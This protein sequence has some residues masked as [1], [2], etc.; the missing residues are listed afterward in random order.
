MEYII[1]PGA[2]YAAKGTEIIIVKIEDEEVTYRRRRRWKDFYFYYGS[3]PLDRVRQQL[4]THS[5]YHP[6]PFEIWLLTGIGAI[7]QFS[8]IRWYRITRWLQE[9]WAKIIGLKL[10]SW[11]SE[12]HPE[13]CWAEICTDMGMGHNLFQRYPAWTCGTRLSTEADRER[14]ECDLCWCGKQATDG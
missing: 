12:R 4:T 8:R 5:A 13:K 11:Y 7:R 14:S 3:M 9:R 10:A 6:L 1:E 2:R